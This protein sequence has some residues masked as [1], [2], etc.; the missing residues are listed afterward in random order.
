LWGKGSY[1]RAKDIISLA[2]P[3]DREQ[4]EKEAYENH[5]MPRAF[6]VAMD[7]NRRYPD[8]RERRNF[9]PAYTSIL[10]GDEYIGDMISGK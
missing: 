2:H 8:W 5:L 1:E 9:K 7:V 6:P 4:L 3:D 10:W